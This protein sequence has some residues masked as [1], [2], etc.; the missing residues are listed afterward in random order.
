MK[1]DQ[2][3]EIKTELVEVL[4][5]I[6]LSTYFKPLSAYFLATVPKLKLGSTATVGCSIAKSM[7]LHTNDTDALQITK[8]A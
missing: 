6:R 3:H 7:L 1:R 4:G 5:S 2:Y 8:S